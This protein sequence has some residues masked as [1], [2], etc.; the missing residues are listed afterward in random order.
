M[1]SHRRCGPRARACG[2]KVAL[3]L[4]P[5]L[6]SSSGFLARPHHLKGFVTCLASSD[7]KLLGNSLFGSV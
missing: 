5:P 3:S 2:P 6:C 4:V 1:P 7:Q